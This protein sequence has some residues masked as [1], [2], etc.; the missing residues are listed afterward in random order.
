[1][2]LGTKDQADQIPSITRCVYVL[3]VH[4]RTHITHGQNVGKTRHET[5][6]RATQ[7]GR[8]TSSPSLFFLAKE[9]LL[10]RVK[11]KQS[12]ERLT[13]LV[14][15]NAADYIFIIPRNIPGRFPDLGTIYH[16]VV[17]STY[18]V[19]SLS[20][21]F[22]L[23]RASSRS[24]AQMTRRIPR[25]TRN[26]ARRVSQIDVELSRSGETCSITHSRR[27]TEDA[28]TDPASGGRELS[29]NLT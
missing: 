7:N 15:H 9:I 19:L 1:M 29:S 6:T 2:Q 11:K 3:Y 25:H 20:L 5:N 12:R 26:P 4:T 16:G 21:F 24:Q 13:R 17:T 28:S 27:D 14:M 10:I 8:S 22:Y 18:V 23:S